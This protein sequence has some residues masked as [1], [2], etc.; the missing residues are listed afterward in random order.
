MGTLSRIS[1]QHPVNFIY[2]DVVI[3]VSRTTRT[4]KDLNKLKF[5]QE[6]YISRI[7]AETND[8]SILNRDCDTKFLSYGTV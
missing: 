2:S 6:E 7:I 4:K 3:T 8:E 1:F 5:K